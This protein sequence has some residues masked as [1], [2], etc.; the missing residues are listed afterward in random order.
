MNAS[1]ICIVTGANAGIG[2]A[3]T[4]KIL[5]ENYTVIGTS[6]SGIIEG[7]NSENLFVFKLDVTNEQ[8]VKTFNKYIRDNFKAIDILVNNAGVGINLGS[9]SVDL[10][11]LRDTFET[12]VFGLIGFTESLLDIVTD[13]GTIFNISSIMGTLN[14]LVKSD[15]TAYRMSKAALNM[16][17]KTLAARLIDRSITVNSI[18]PGWV[19]TKMGGN[20]APLTPE[21]SAN[22]IFQ[23]LEKKLP[24]GTF[25][26]AEDGSE[27]EW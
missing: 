1:K 13:G 16:Y 10:N 18:H 23:L 6:R 3:L 17:T 21:F 26:N 24:A 5:S 8:S 2:L 11:D 9:V 19:K 14:R 20:E 27:M 7:I 25:W 12:N 15:S 22:G 4:K